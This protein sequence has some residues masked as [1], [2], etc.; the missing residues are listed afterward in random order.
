MKGLAYL[1]LAAVVIYFL[2]YPFLKHAVNRKKLFKWFLITYAITAVL[3]TIGSL[4]MDK[5]QPE[6]FEEGVK[7]MKNKDEVKDQ[8]GEFK[9]LKFDERDL[10]KETDNPADLKFTLKGSKGVLQVESRVAKN[11][12]GDWYLIE[13]SKDSLIERH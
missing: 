9:S 11:S 13:I 1:F 3:S 4:Y 6:S 5:G 12:K 7:I 2:F 10:P 8:I